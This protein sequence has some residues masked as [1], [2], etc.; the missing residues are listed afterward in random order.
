MDGTIGG[1]FVSKVK[2]PDLDEFLPDYMHLAERY[3][4]LD[5]VIS[6]TNYD[7]SCCFWCSNGN[8][9]YE[10]YEETCGCRDCEPYLDKIEE[11]DPDR[12]DY[13][14][15]K[16]KAGFEELYFSNWGTDHVRSDV[17]D[18]VILTIWIHFGETNGGRGGFQI[19]RL[20]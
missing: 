11:Y 13:K 15:G 5:M 19:S 20:S 9:P 18:S 1:N 7:E 12:S 14:S 6:Y 10:G 17:G 4:F 2:Y 3:P 8:T 16:E